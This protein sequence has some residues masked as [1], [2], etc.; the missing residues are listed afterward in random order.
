MP[1]K[2]GRDAFKNW[3]NNYLTVPIA[4][5]TQWER[6]DFSR[7]AVLPLD[8]ANQNSHYVAMCVTKLECL[9][10]ILFSNK[11]PC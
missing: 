4:P 8:R 3:Q 1:L 10:T 5:F 7:Q 9:C 6:W 2:S 11:H